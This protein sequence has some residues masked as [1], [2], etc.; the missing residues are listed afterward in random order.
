MRHLEQHRSER[1]GWLRAA[2]LGANDGI[3]SVGSILVGVASANTDHQ[4]IVLA[5]VAGL[6]AGALSMAAGEYVSVSSQSDTESADRAR[7]SAELRDDPEGELIELTNIYVQR[8]LTRELAGQVAEQLTTH[9]ALGTHLRDELGM[10]E[11]HAAR[12]LQAALASAAAFGV[13][14]AL[15]VLVSLVS[16]ATWI[17]WLVAAATVAGLTILGTL[18]AWAGGSSLWKG[19]MRVTFWGIVAM[20]VTSLV[21]W[22]FGVAV[23]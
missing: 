7:E 12:P 14:G 21:G 17:V 2:V 11:T 16:P 15:P 20:A 4:S 9:D 6:T 10:T 22:L 19:A 3:L 8:G 13:G 18:S 1:I 23:A 5:G